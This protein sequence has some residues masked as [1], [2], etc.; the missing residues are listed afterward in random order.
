M[1]QE[2]IG[3]LSEKERK[4]GVGTG[5]DIWGEKVFGP[6]TIEKKCPFYQVSWSI[7]QGMV[8]NQRR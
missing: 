4:N 2:E 8:S 6:S 1:E 7:R 3:F 5:K